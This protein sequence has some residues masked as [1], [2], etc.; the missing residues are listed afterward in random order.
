LD[1]V[2]WTIA[3][4][5]ALTAGTFWYEARTFRDGL[6][7]AQ[8]ELVDLRTR[9]SLATT[10][11]ATLTSQ[12]AAYEKAF[13]VVV[14]D[15]QK[16]KGLVKL[17]RFPSPAAGKD[18][19]LWVIDPADGKPVSAGVIKPPEGGVTRAAFTPERRM[20]S[21]DTFAISVEPAGGSPEPRGEVILVGK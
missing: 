5:L 8:R 13:A 17:E 21:A 19:Q 18:Y 14:F 4:G 3:A 15:A 6:A 16:Q 20:P 2:P 11:I 7:T 1:W 12:V 9:D 10:R